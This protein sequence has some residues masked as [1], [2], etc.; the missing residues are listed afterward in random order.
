[1]S[2]RI[3]SSHVVISPKFILYYFHV[4]KNILK[5]HVILPSSS[6]KNGSI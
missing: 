4:T 2:I 3:L 1:M 5:C 6:N